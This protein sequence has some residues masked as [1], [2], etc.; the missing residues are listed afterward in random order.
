MKTKNIILSITLI[1]IAAVGFG[2]RT[3]ILERL[4]PSQDRE[5]EYISANYSEHNHVDIWKHDKEGRASN[6]VSWD[7]Y[8]SPKASKTIYVHLADILSEKEIRTES[9]MTRPFES[10]A[11]ENDII[12]EP[13]MAAPFETG[14]SVEEI[15][16][17]EEELELETWMTAPFASKNIIRVE[18]WM[19]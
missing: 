17:K 5:V 14:I 15:K 18:E 2:Q 7:V 12:M 16:V 10:S 8:E 4:F 11:L 13:W 1:A 19:L 9:W 3:Y 6:K